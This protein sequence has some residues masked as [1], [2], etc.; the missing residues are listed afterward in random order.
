MI[1]LDMRGDAWRDIRQTLQSFPDPYVCTL[2]L[3]L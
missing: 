1:G 3:H 2:H